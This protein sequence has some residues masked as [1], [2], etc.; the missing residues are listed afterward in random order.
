MN[1]GQSLQYRVTKAGIAEENA[2]LRSLES[3]K[4]D[5]EPRPFCSSIRNVVLVLLLVVGSL[6]T[7]SILAFYVSEP[8]LLKANYFGRQC[9]NN[10]PIRGNSLA[11]STGSSLPHYRFAIVTCSDA[12]GTI[13]QRSFEGL[14]K[15]VTP[16]KER[17]VKLHGYDFIDASDMVNM[18]RPPSWSKILA[19]K[20]HLPQYDWVFWNDAD[21]LVTNFSISLEAIIMS[22]VGDVDFNDM[23]DLIVTEDVTGVNAGMFFVRN[24][25]W[26]QQFLELWW[27]QTSFVKPFGQ[28]KSGDNNALKYL[29]RSMSDHD[30]NQHVGITRMQCLF[31]SNLWRPS[32]RSCHRLLTMTRSVWQGV[33]A[34]GD[35]MVHLAGLNDKKKWA[36][37]V[38]LDIED[39]EASDMN[40]PRQ[41]EANIG[42]EMQE[43][44]ENTS[45]SVEDSL[46]TFVVGEESCE[47]Q[48]ISP[49]V[50]ATEGGE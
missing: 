25:E 16:N 23:P 43:I 32:L 13:P 5:P 30:R 44:D 33:Y 24:T 27:N 21:S 10:N 2:R 35:F 8:I 15:I 6:L 45:T 46:C 3:F 38:L 40:A 7:S 41:T 29:I 36:K 26:S 49:S 1:L 34:R 50:V 17:Y 28:S 48:Q 31:N 19:V 42:E 37:K 11:P 39:M 22:V 47:S 9:M 18:Q 12:S 20:R 4:V 14:M